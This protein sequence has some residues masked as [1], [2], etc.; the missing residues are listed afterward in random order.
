MDKEIALTLWKNQMRAYVSTEH[1]TRSEIYSLLVE[2]DIP[3]RDRILK[4]LAVCP[5]CNTEFH[6]M[7]QAAQECRYIDVALPTYAA[8]RNLGYCEIETEGGKYVIRIRQSFKDK[9]RGIISVTVTP[10]L[11]ENLEGSPII[12][13]DGENR[14]IV[15]GVLVN[16][17]ISQKIENIDIINTERFFI[18]SQK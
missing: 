1:L 13:R 12:L 8:T 11:S 18:E 7:L 3:N 9:K 15:E 17:Q 6:K 10:P 2:N 16:G 4:H 14:K 5:D